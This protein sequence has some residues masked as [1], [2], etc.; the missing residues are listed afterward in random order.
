MNLSQH[1]GNALLSLYKN[2]NRT[3]ILNRGWAQTAFVSSYFAYKKYLEDSNAK[4]I[5]NYPDIFRNGSIL[6]IGANIG[7]TAYVFSKA[8]TSPYKVFAFEP[9]ERNLSILKKVA[10][11]HQISD[12]LVITAAAVGDKEGEIELWRNDG[13]H[14]DH[15]VLTEEF[16]KQLKGNVQIQKTPLITVDGFLKKQSTQ[17]IAFIKIDVQGYEL[18]VCNGMQ[19]TLAANP[20]CVVGF[21]Y[22]PSIMEALGYNA[23][24]LIQFFQNRNFLFYR[25]N[26]NGTLA[27]LNINANG[28][29]TLR[30]NA[31]EYHEYFDILCSRK[32]L[33]N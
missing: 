22:C 4:L 28:N 31:H 8:I 12:K 30:N 21:E 23:Q 26:K 29:I 16:R 10:N 18:A 3:G 27:P 14:A 25:L 2:F 15:R 6:D 19:E 1:I 13:H 17:A 32:N 9:E 11:K 33:L 5:K 20:N 7:Y 24:E